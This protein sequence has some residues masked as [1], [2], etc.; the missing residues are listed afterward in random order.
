MMKSP[1][2]AVI[3]TEDFPKGIVASRHKT[4]EEAVAVAYNYSFDVGTV[5][6][7][8]IEETPDVAKRFIE[9]EE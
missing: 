3:C 4:K 7:Y 2:I 6:A 8:A 9:Q 1:Y 5:K